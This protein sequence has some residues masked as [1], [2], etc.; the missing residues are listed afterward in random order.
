MELT[1]ERSERK[2]AAEITNAIRCI[3]TIPMESLRV[4]VNEDWICLRGALNEQH[5]KEAA[6]EVVRQFSGVRG[7]TNLITITPQAVSQ[8]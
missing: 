4:T 1:D 6:E 7:V 5:Q 8:N 2:M 3:T